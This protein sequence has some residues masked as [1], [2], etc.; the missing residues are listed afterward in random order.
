MFEKL[1]ICN[2]K[3]PYQRLRTRNSI[4]LPRNTFIIFSINLSVALREFIKLM[5]ILK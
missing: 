5:V 3:Y 1:D 4:P 2:L